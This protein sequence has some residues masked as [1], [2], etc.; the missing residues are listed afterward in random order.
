[1]VQSMVPPRHPADPYPSKGKSQTN[2]QTADEEFSE[3]GSH[4]LRMQIE[5]Q[6]EGFYSMKSSLAGGFCTENE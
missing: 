5:L 6:K 3:L 4:P 1:M 2:P